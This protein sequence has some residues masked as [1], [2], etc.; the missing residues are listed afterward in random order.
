LPAVLLFFIGIS[1]RIGISGTAGEKVEKQE[2]EQV[3]ISHSLHHD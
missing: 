1:D 3:P 2:I